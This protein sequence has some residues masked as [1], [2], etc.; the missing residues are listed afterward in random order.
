MIFSRENDV[1]AV[2][3]R[4]IFVR[5]VAC[6]RRNSYIDEKYLSTIIE[7]YEDMRFTEIVLSSWLLLPCT[8]CVYI[9]VTWIQKLV[10]VE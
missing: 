5:F 2:K 9:F 7:G 6:Y 1:N 4:G 10:F 8:Y 3:C